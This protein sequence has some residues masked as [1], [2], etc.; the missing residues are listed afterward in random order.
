MY[1]DGS[2]RAGRSWTYV[3]LGIALFGIPAAT[4]VFKL[5]GFT[6]SDTAV[7]VV[8]ELA[9]LALVALL[10]WIVRVGERM[11]LAS[12]GLKRQPVFSAV[13]WT[14]AVMVAFAAVLF[15]CLGVVLPALGLSYGSGGGP[16]AAVPVTLVVVTRAGL[17]EE[18]FYRGYA[19][20]RIEALT[21]NRWVAALIPLIL[22]ASFHYSQGV[23]G[24]I[25]ALMIGAVATAVYLWKRNLT[26]LIAAHFLLDFIPNVLLPLLSGSSL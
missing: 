21:G 19:I 26:I 22:F 24:V 7:I 13:L 4:V 3:G 11:P 10:L 12:I 2:V 23:A 5:A 9:I 1:M 6:R 20:E 25:I 8:R 16:A 14:L 15:G 18:V 17:A